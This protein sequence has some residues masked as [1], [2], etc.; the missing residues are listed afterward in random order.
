[1]VSW[2]WHSQICFLQRGTSLAPGLCSILSNTL[3]CSASPPINISSPKFQRVF[4]FTWWLWISSGPGNFQ[5]SIRLVKIL[6]SSTKPSL[7]PNVFLPGHSPPALEDLWVLVPCSYLFSYNYFILKFFILYKHHIVY[8]IIYNKSL[9]T[10]YGFSS[11]FGYG[12]I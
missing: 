3:T 5:T 2:N 6:P 1:M 9:F 4:L 7:L 8:K 12:L 11:Q 10:V